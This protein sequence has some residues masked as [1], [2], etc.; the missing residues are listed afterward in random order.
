MH[1]NI[2]WTADGQSVK[3]AFTEYA[4]FF[5]DVIVAIDPGDDTISYTIEGL[6]CQNGGYVM[7]GRPPKKNTKFAIF[8]ADQ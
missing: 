1:K 8:L 3:Y 7:F 2:E 4:R 5:Q 6:G